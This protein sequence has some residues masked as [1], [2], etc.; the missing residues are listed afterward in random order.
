MPD[1]NLDAGTPGESAAPVADTTKTAPDTGAVSASADKTAPTALADADGADGGAVA[2]VKVTASWPDDWRTKLAGND[3]GY[4]KTLARY[5]DPTGLAKAHKNL[6]AKMKAGEFKGALPENATEQQ[7][8]A[9]RKEHGIP[10]A[11]E[12]Y[13]KVPLPNGL[14][15]PDADQAVLGEFAG[16]AHQVN[17]TPSQWSGVMGWYADRVTAMK[18]AEFQRDDQLRV[19]AAVAL[20]EQW[21]AEYKANLNSI[22]NLLA[23]APDKVRE[24][25]Q[26]ARLPDGTK[27]GSNPE[28][29]GWL[30]NLAREVNPAA[31]LTPSGTT[32]AMSGRLEE[33]R[34]M[35]RDDPAKY[36]ND[37]AL[38]A[39][40]LKLIEGELKL[41]SRGRAA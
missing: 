1:E 8:T 22:G 9:W 12:E 40:E 28:V 37:R 19:D 6:L 13:T 23:G 18:D 10:V 7:M 20:K 34:K 25:F 11:A 26:H 35:R 29:L 16:V 14:V 36:D 4:A 5:S 24:E 41:R 15:L 39:E 38:E 3:E 32:A 27:L 21:G 2:D 31:P 30:A 33:I 17:L